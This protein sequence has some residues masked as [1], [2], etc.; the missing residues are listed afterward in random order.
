MDAAT[1]DYAKTLHIHHFKPDE[2]PWRR[3]GQ[4]TSDISPATEVQK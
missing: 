3:L 2:V 1:Y 4:C